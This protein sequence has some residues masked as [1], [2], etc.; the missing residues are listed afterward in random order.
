MIPDPAAG[1]LWRAI[2]L[3]LFVMCG[4]CALVDLGGC[5][6]D[7]HAANGA[8]RIV[9]I[10]GAVTETVFALGAGA[11]VVATDTSSV[12]PEQV[13]ALPKVGYQR[14]LNAEGILAFSPDLVL[15]ADEAGPPAAIDQLTAAGVKIVRVPPAND[16][17]AAIA[18]IG[19][20]AGA[21]G[22]PG[23]AL[24]AQVR[25]D[26]AAALARVPAAPR[27]K[28]A[29]AFSLTAGSLM[30]LGDDTPGIAMVELAGGV[31]AVTGF[32]GFK[33]VSAEALIAAA[34]DVIV[35]PMHSFTQRGGLDGV[36]ALPGVAETPA[37]KARRIVPVD[38]LLLLGFGPRLAQG[39]D[40]I[41]RG[42]R[43]NPAT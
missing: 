39:I 42:L 33:A 35:I 16:P 7:K 2:A 3:A 22:R 23:D 4:A 41:G 24:A 36:L 10:G 31:P 25:T 19:V 27:P 6:R 26:V 18:R 12:Y 29:V 20:V 43:A 1:R 21:L 28:V 37:G 5:A 40:E 11:E 30:L 9:S 15:L 13:H 14:M 32:T 17:D 8:R 34:P 38:D